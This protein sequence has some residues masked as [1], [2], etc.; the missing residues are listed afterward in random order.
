MLL[1]E[2]ASRPKDGTIRRREKF[3]LFPTKI[4]GYSNYKTFTKQIIWFEKYVVLENWNDDHNEWRF[5]SNKRL[6]DEVA[7]ALKS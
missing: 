5:H 7:E 6:I 3:A 2:Y 4:Y 1:K